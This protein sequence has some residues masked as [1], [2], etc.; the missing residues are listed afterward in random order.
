M[1][2]TESRLTDTPQQTLL[3]GLALFCFYWLCFKAVTG[4]LLGVRCFLGCPHYPVLPIS[5]VECVACFQ[6][7][8]QLRCAE[9][10]WAQEAPS[11][12]LGRHSL[13][14]EP[15]QQ[16]RGG[17]LEE[18]QRARRAHHGLTPTCL[19]RQQV[20]RPPGPTLVAQDTC[21][22]GSLI[23]QSDTSDFSWAAAPWV[24]WLWRL[25]AGGPDGHVEGMS[26]DTLVL[27]GVAPLAWLR[28]ARTGRLTEGSLQMQCS[29]SP[30]GWTRSAGAF[31]LGAA[32]CSQEGPDCRILLRPG[33]GGA[34]SH[35]RRTEG[36]AGRT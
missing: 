4:S 21:S 35:A 18:T 11:S 31:H 29:G 16:S 33:A 17:F 26:M 5:L 13:H 15:G 20:T 36:R 2:F 34:S 24:S 23:W 10:G 22:P 14:R 9:Q 1:G 30:L 8:I 32:G 27:W 28:C 6:L 12:C 25:P 19:S 3:G 7:D